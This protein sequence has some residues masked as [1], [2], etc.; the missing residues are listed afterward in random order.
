MLSLIARCLKNAIKVHQ[1]TPVSRENAQLF[2]SGA[3]LGY[4]HDPQTRAAFMEVLTK[5][6]QQGTEFETLAETALADRC[7]LPRSC[8][9]NHKAP[10]LRR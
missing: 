5:I 7:A 1:P 10:T 6:L 9:V 4:H 3:G 8:R 2:C